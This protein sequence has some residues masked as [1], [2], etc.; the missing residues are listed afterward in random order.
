M[1]KFIGRQQEVGI[2]RESSRGTV[3]APSQWLPKVNFSVEDKVTK[4][5]FQGGYG[6]ILGGDDAVVSDKYAQGDLEFEVQDNSIAMLLYS[7]F[8]SLTSAAY[9]SVYKHTLAIANSVQHQSLSLFMNEPIGAAEAVTKSLVYPR[10]MIDT[11][12]LTS[13]PGE[14]VMAKA[15]I[16]A[17]SHKDW[18]RQ[19]PSYTAQN[20]VT[21]QHASVKIA[22]NL[23]GLDAASK[24]TVRELTL[25]IKKNVVRE[26][27][28]G[29]VQPID[30]LNRRI[31]ISG[32][33]KLTYE[34][35]TF[36]DYMLN[37]TKKSLRINL[38]NQAVTI[39]ATTPQ[40]Q[41]DLSVCDFT[42]WEPAHGIDDIATQDIMFN[43]LY[44]VSNNVLIGSNSFVVNSTASY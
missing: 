44:D 35:R 37:G 16:V 23:A 18:T 32:K 42:E 12:E 20:K 25:T 26:P 29:T 39:G 28:L 21:H 17:A 33:I 4:A 14:F 34:D 15:G 10:A 24:V 22:A 8:G 1:A 36:R 43:A 31:E 9:L 5:R 11:L 19:T 7:V 41:L 6:N 38:N 13:R 3:A 40:V 2:G 30:I 27:S